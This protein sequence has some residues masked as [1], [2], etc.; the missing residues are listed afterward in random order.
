MKEAIKKWLGIKEVDTSGVDEA[1][2]RMIERLNDDIDS[3]KTDHQIAEDLAAGSK[4][5]ARQLKEE[6][7]DLKL[8]KKIETE[9]I[10][11]LVKITEERKDLELDKERLKLEREKDAEVSQIREDCAGE[12][13]EVRDE[14]TKKQEDTLQKQIEDGN[15]MFSE[16]MARLPNINGM[17]E[18]G[19]GSDRTKPVVESK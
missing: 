14:Y 2:D 12:I 17:V 1:K 11:H 7:A 8:E 6:V 5:L 19:L 10:K 18:V 16:V 4:K 9:D 15:K 3:L 13:K